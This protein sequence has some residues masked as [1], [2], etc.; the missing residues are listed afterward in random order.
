MSRKAFYRPPDDATVDQFARE[1]CERFAAQQ[2][3]PTISSGETVRGLS[4]FLKLLMRLEAHRLNQD[5]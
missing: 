2:S 3:D 5:Q 4:T 1:V